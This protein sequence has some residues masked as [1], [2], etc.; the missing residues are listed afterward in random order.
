MEVTNTG[1]IIR[2]KSRI[3]KLVI[4]LFVFSTAVMLVP[5]IPL[6]SQEM[7]LENSFI[8]I[9]ILGILGLFIWIIIGTGYDI[10][11]THVFYYS[12]PMNGKIEVSSIHTIIS[13]KTL[14]VGYKP[15]TATKGLIIKYNKYDEIYFSPSTNDRFIETILK[16]KPDIK[17]IR[18]E[19]NSLE[20]INNSYPKH[21]FKLN[22]G[23]QIF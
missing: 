20:F 9:L 14:W 13:G 2:F 3:G 10:T 19:L 12:G 22:P 8:F 23:T 4:A 5:V 16:I 11:P 7:N 18:N 6:L 15:A 21:L 17:I 1:N